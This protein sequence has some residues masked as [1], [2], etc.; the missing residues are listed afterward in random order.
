MY[1]SQWLPYGP[2]SK[3]VHHVELGAIWDI[4]YSVSSRGC[5]CEGCIGNM[6]PLNGYGDMALSSSF[7]S[8][9]MAS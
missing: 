3:A 9:V 7:S 1:Q 4:P 8:L 2:W 6:V 5:A